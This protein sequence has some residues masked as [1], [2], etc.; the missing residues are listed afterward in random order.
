MLHL[1]GFSFEDEFG[2]HSWDVS[3]VEHGVSYALQ[4]RLDRRH[5]VHHKAPAQEAVVEP[6]EHHAWAHLEQLRTALNRE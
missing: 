1:N 2:H 4:Q 5:T 3:L 6:Q